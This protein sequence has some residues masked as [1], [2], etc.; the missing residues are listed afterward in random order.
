MPL[1]S[2]EEEILRR[3]AASNEGVYGVFKYLAD[4]SLDYA[5]LSARG[6]FQ[7]TRKAGLRISITDCRAAV[8]A[9]SKIG[10]G[11]LSKDARGNPSIKDLEVPT[12][13]IGSAAIMNTKN[14]RRFRSDREARGIEAT[15]ETVTASPRELKIY[16]MRKASNI[17]IT[18]TIN[19]YPVILPLPD[20]LKPDQLSALIERLKRVEDGY[21][22][23]KK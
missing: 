13:E 6:L 20:D 19:G 8:M 23:R 10:I 12:R 15:A 17:S 22:P 21:D 18:V 5:T 16:P 9:V 7:G 4:H 14:L 11:K 1:N 2:A 3:A